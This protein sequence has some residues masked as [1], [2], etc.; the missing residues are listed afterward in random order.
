[1]QNIFL[2]VQSVLNVLVKNSLK[3][4]KHRELRS[5]IFQIHLKKVFKNTKLKI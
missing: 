2:S 5:C 3:K 4:I 1:M